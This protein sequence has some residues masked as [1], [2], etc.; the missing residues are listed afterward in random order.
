MVLITE[1]AAA[2]P[3]FWTNDTLRAAITDAL[4]H[5]LQHQAPRA[6]RLL[7]HHAFVPLVRS[8]P[9]AHMQAWLSGPVST[10]MAYLPGHLHSQWAEL[11]AKAS[12]QVQDAPGSQTQDEIVHEVCRLA[13]D[14]CTHQSGRQCHPVDLVHAPN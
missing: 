14:M 3:G 6:L 4:L 9:P 7:L 2:V 13:C 11:H 1:S 8:C 5:G 10:L 12:G